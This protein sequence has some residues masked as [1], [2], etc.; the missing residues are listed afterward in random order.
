MPGISPKII[1]TTESHHQVF[2]ISYGAWESLMTGTASGI[3]AFI[4]AN[5]SGNHHLPGTT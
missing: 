2:D 4:V 3:E 5:R 1:N